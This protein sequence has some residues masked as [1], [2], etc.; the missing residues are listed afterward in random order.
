MHATILKFGFPNSLIKEYEHWVVLLRPNQV[1]LG[2]LVLA[3]KGEECS[4]GQVSK[5][6]FNEMLLVVRDIERVLE[7]AFGMDKINYLALMMVDKHVHFHI[8]PRYSSPRKFREIIYEDKNWPTPPDL[9][10]CIELG[11][12]KIKEIK[13]YLINMW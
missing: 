3:Y 11:D 7:K 8:I 1:T 10:I 2:S 9:S 5:D 4:L 13:D 12:L 6:A